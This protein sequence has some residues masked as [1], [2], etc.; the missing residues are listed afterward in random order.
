L[1]LQGLRDD[2]LH[3]ADIHEA[4]G[5]GPLAG[6]LNAGCAILIRKPQQALR[7]ADEGPRDVTV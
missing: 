6:N 4:K 2:P 7:L 3:P 1:F 5:H